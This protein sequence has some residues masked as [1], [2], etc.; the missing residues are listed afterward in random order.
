MEPIDTVCR[1]SAAF[2]DLRDDELVEQVKHLAQRERRASVA[3]IRSLVEFDAR[4][5]YLREGC[6][7]LFTYCTQ[8][9]H[10]SEGSAYNRIETARAARR[11]P[12]VLEALERGDVT[13]TTVRLLAPHLTPGNRR[14]VLTAARYKSR[15]GIQ[16]LIASLSPRPEAATV[17]RRLAPQQQPKLE[18]TSAFA[19]APERQISPPTAAAVS[20]APSSSVG[21]HRAATPTPQPRGTAVTP[22]APERYR[23]Q[24]TLTREAHEKLRRAQALLRH[25]LPSGDIASILDRALTLL[26]DHL[27]RHRFARVATPR[28]S[29]SESS[30]S[31]RHIPAAVRRAVW[32]RDEGRCA[33]VGRTGRCR[34]T[35]FLEFHHVIPYA[36]GGA[37]TSDNIQLR[38]AAHNQ[39]EAH[40]FF[41]DF[42][43]RETQEVW[44]DHAGSTNPNR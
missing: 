41:G 19:A 34:E 42:L 31:G 21:Q 8:V 17:V 28:L 40:L 7:S 37:A 24:V 2:A 25:A 23:L 29:A 22:L 9:L 14:E 15:Q 36:T 35:S 39:Y 12:E 11:H 3:L 16:E 27:E 32:Q 1:D 18:S 43:I 26:I 38:C 5:L 13:L 6:S 20:P 10:L 33:F 44:R 4:R 30:A